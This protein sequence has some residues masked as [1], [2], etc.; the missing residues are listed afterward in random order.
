MVVDPDH[1][2]VETTHHSQGSGH[3]GGPHRGRQPVLAVVVEGDGVLFIVEGHDHGDRAEDLLL[4][5]PHVGGD[6]PDDGRLV[7]VVLVEG[8]GLDAVAAGENPRSFGNRSGDCFFDLV[9]LGAGDD[10]AEPGSGVE[11]IP[12][13]DG[14]GPRDQAVDPAS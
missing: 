2:D 4:C 14:P 9:T 11:G 6:V 5:H 1:A 8:W 13:P 3:V 12:G 10:R 7:E